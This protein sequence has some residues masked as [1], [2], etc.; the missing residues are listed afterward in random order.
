[1]RPCLDIARL[2][3]LL[4]AGSL[5]LTAG[6]QAAETFE[7]NR[8]PEGWSVIGA[9]ALTPSH[10]RHKAGGQSLLWDWS[11]G[12]RLVFSDA[13]A[14]DGAAGFSAW[15]CNEAPSEA[16]LQFSFGTPERLAD[17][18]APYAFSYPLH[19]AGW[20]YCTVSLREDIS[21]QGFQGAPEVTAMVV[22]APTKGSGRLWLDLVQFPALILW[23]RGADRQLPFLN[24]VRLERF[25]W[26]RGHLEFDDLALDAM[27]D[28]PATEVERADLRRMQARYRDW[29]LGE[30]VDLTD[31]LAASRHEAFLDRARQ[32][33]EALGD[34]LARPLVQQADFRL[35][36]GHL[37]ALA[38][39]YHTD[40]PAN[41][42]HRDPATLEAI[43]SAFGHTQE[44][45]WAAGSLFGDTRVFELITGGNEP[46]VFLMREELRAE[47]M[48]ASVLAGM[49]WYSGIGRVL[50]ETDHEGISAD[51]IRGRYLMCLAWVLSLDDLDLQAMWM[52]RLS[53]WLSRGLLPA[54]GWG[55]TIKP[56]F[57]GFHHH[58]IVGNSYVIDAL[59]AGAACNYLLHDTAFA[60][61]QAATHSLRN[62]LLAARWYANKYDVPT[63]LALRWPFMTDQ[64]AGLL[65]AFAY[66]ALAEDDPQGPVQRAFL[67]L[68][69]PEVAWLP[70]RA[71]PQGPG[72]SYV[73][74]MGAV[75]AVQEA[76]LAG[77]EPEPAPE[78]FRSFPYGGLAVH[79]RGEWMVATKGWSRYVTNYEQARNRNIYGRY[80][81]HGTTLIYA[82]GDPVSR[83]ASGYSE[84]GWDW[85][86]WP[87]AT[88]IYLP[89]HELYG[90]SRYGD[91]C[92]YGRRRNDETF[93]GA[94]EHP[95][96]H[97]MFAMRLSD[98]HNAPG[99]RARKSYLYVDDTVICL[100]SGIVNDDPDHPVET[101]LFQLALPEENTPTL[102]SAAGPTAA[103][104]LDWRPEGDGA[105]WLMDHVGNGYWVPDAAD[106]RLA[107]RNQHTPWNGSLE[108]NTRGDFEVAWL[109]HGPAPQD[110]G[111]EYVIRVQT[112]PEEMQAHAQEPGHRVMHRDDRAHIVHHLDTAITGY[113]LF[114]AGEAPGGGLV[115]AVDTPCLIMTEPH[116]EGYVLS[117]CDPD[118]G[119][120]DDD[121][122][123]PA[124][125]VEVTLEGAWEPVE[126]E[127]VRVVRKEQGQT[128]LAFTCGDGR[129]TVTALV[130]D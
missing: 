86:R 105:V 51:T 120:T 128:V 30:G 48:L 117:V 34:M 87:G 47:G 129:S 7:G 92:P 31:P 64:F 13:E 54:P 55:G 6:L 85:N 123:S 130:R 43:L 65:P 33:S 3:L 9:G 110:A 17:G 10:D 118:F 94:V 11:A 91:P 56:D 4:S 126:T 32:A 116:G 38:V 18:D 63:T 119:W 41:P 29:L 81:S 59:H 42:F 104:P 109:D 26:I 125:V 40:A 114:E 107:R 97:G 115:Q 12:D 60:M 106:L 108:P 14:F 102:I 68:W 24:Q 127:A 80:T 70:D 84:P 27:P 75:R 19:F 113:A 98:P 96:G 71:L 122:R 58:M 72:Y 16:I 73:G 88:A 39:A 20:R 93:V 79:R 8:V 23:S 121:Q 22:Q 95:G 69:D 52:R 99:F 2:T 112:T 53:A 35:V 1:M 61:S 103:F 5:L 28:R 67:R 78:G 82:A 44:Q 90:K 46:A 100:G 15:I 66:L 76:A 101:T 37:G 124:G 83:E 25:P 111:Y 57:T 89:W 45:G 62:A 36:M 74:T 21:V 50:D 77:G 49:R